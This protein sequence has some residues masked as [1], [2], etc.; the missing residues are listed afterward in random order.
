MSCF[1]AAA[2]RFLVLIATLAATPAADIRLEEA[3]GHPVTL[4]NRTITEIR[5]PVDGLEPEERVERIRERLADLSP[6]ALTQ[7]VTVRPVAIGA[8]QARL[9]TVGSTI[10]LALLP[11]DVPAGMDLDAS[12]QLAATRLGEVLRARHDQRQ[13]EILATGVAW[14]LGATVLLILALWGILRLCSAASGRV[15]A[16]PLHL[17][18]IAGLDPGPGVKG[19]IRMFLR[20][21]GWAAAAAAIYLWLALVLAQFPYTKP[22]AAVLGHQILALGGVVGSA[23]VGALP[24]LGMVAVIVVLTRMAARALDAFFA[25]LADGTLQISWMLPETAQAT[26]R[27]AGILL[28]LFAL[29]V[30]YPYIPGSSS[31]AFKGVS[32]FAGLLLTLGSAGMVNQMMSG[33]VVVYARMMKP[34]DMVK[35]GEVSGQVTELGFLSTKVRTPTGHEVTMPNAILTGSAVANFSRFDPATGPM[36]AAGVTIGYDTPWR[37]VHALLELAASRTPGIDRGAPPVVVQTG[38]SDFYA[39]YQLRCRIDRVEQRD[40]VLS[41]LHARIQ[42]AFNEFGVQIMSPHFNS[43]PAQP[44]LVAKG[45]EAPPPAKG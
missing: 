26:R 3:E 24:G 41:D 15:A 14:A 2:V 43:Q 32:V 39:E 16:M 25:N 4:W 13:P 28:W 35:V 7:P 44:V 19:L 8:T 33:L 45:Q 34:G 37:Q 21:C 31:D 36:V 40:R 29:T 30:A 6:E 17:P 18:R 38:L 9:I 27:I 23:I 42:D 20:G 5:A 10:I 1:R 22:L 12:A 11:G